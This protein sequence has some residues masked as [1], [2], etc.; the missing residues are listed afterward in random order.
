MQAEHDAAAALHASDPRAA[1]P[2]GSLVLPSVAKL[3]NP[4]PR[5]LERVYQESDL[6]LVLQQLVSPPL[7]TA[8]LSAPVRQM[9]RRAKGTRTGLTPPYLDRWLPNHPQEL[10]WW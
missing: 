3:P 2:P 5:A 10:G 6:P 9:T 7:L 8:L 4:A 1:V